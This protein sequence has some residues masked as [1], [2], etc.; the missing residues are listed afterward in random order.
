MTAASCRRT[1][2][3]RIGFVLPLTMLLGVLP[4]FASPKNSPQKAKHQAE[5]D[6][7]LQCASCHGKTG[8]GDTPVGKS[9]KA[10]DLRSPE[11]QK[12]SDA[13]L[14]EVIADGRGNMPSFSSSLTQEEIRA[15]VTYLRK[16]AKTSS[17]VRSSD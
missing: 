2:Q 10:A 3:A 9:L 11:V 16:F 14:S 17:K 5:S 1:G 13:Q 8:A 15:L 4:A 6:Y 7:Q 12:Q